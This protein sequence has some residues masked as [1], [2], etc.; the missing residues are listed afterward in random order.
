MIF[1]KCLL[2]SY[3]LTLFICLREKILFRNA[4]LRLKID[5][6]MSFENLLYA[7][8]Y[9]RTYWIDNSD[10]EI[11]NRVLYKIAKGAFTKRDMYDIGTSTEGQ[12][13]R[14]AKT[15]KKRFVRH[16][17]QVKVTLYIVVN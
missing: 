10:G 6:D 5:S 7:M 9:E 13:R 12:K 3:F 4:L 15:N 2:I 16:L 11:T 14:R 1:C 17:G 8:V